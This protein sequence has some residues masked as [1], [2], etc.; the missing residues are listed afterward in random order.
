MQF[1]ANPT[2]LDKLLK[3]P[4]LAKELLPKGRAVLDDAKTTAP[5]DT[6]LYR[7]SLELWPDVTDRVQ[8]RVGVRNNKVPYAAELNVRTGHLSK[9]LDAVDRAGE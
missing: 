4:D 8:I 2:F 9:S 3:D 5:V 7:D 1:K 6:G